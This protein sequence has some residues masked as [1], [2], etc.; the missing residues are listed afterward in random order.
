MFGPSVD[1]VQ[2]ETM[3]GMQMFRQREETA[4][5][6]IQAAWRRYKTQEWYRIIT[7]LRIDACIRIQRNW[8]LIK[9]LKMGPKIRKAKRD[10]AAITVQKYM[11]GYL[12]QKHALK[13]MAETKI[14]VTAAFFQSM[15][16][17]LLLSAQITIAYQWRRYI[18]LKRREEALEKEM[19][20]KN[21]TAVNKKPPRVSKGGNPLMKKKTNPG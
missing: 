14:G 1:T 16:D 17:D 4:A 8:K 18:K 2:A 13:Q 5:I 15:R 20:S 10:A 7:Q 3:I 6:R 9:F 11:K 21:K 12:T 19:A